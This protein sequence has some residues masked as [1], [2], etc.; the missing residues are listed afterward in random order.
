MRRQALSLSVETQGVPGYLLD[1]RILVPILSLASKIPSPV[2]LDTAGVGSVRDSSRPVWRSREARV[3]QQES[4]SGG[5]IVSCVL[6]RLC[7][8]AQLPWVLCQSI[9]LR[10][11][12]WF[13]K[14]LISY[15]FV[16][17]P[18]NVT[19]HLLSLKSENTDGVKKVILLRELHYINFY[20][21]SL[22]LTTIPSVGIIYFIN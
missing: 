4:S 17:F 19:N 2:A 8:Y 22:N 12:S 5:S 15:Q 1:R 21:I 10:S 14:L 7:A 18:F 16:P 6:S 20:F 11:S 13:P 3:W 9:I